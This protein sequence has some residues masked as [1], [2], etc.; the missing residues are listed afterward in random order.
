[1][2]IGKA[3]DVKAELADNADELSIKSSTVEVRVHKD[4]FRLRAYRSNSQTPFWKQRLSDLFTSDIIPTSIVSHEG[5]EATFEAFSLNPS[6]GIYGLGERFD[7][8]GRRGRPVDFV[9]HDA[10]GTSNQRSYINVPFFWSTN[11]YGCFV[12]SVARTEWDMG[13]SEAG[14]VGFCTE[15]PFMDYFI[16]E[17][18]TPKDLLRK[19]TN[20]LTGTSP[21]PSIWTFGLWLSRNSYQGWDI[22]DEVLEKL[23][24]LIYR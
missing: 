15:E 14:T 19:Y 13:M 8:V 20:D 10:I 21:L 22:V 18:Q 4:P 12:N 11:G 3:Q 24:S 9:N 23:K 2:L 1:M 17:G 5:R 7:G 16:I 6:E